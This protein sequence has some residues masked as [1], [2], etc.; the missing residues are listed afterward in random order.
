MTCLLVD[1]QHV[2]IEA[3][4]HASF[5]SFADSVSK[6]SSLQKSA[7]FKHKVS[8]CGASSRNVPVAS[9]VRCKADRNI[10]SRI[11]IIYELTIIRGYDFG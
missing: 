11:D 6:P 7:N 9:S 4:N 5:I 3:C 8:Y 2:G 10:T 1:K